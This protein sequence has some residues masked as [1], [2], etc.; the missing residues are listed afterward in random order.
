MNQSEFKKRRQRLMRKMGKGSIAIVPTAPVRQRNS[1]VDHRFRPDSDF[2]YLTGFAEPEAICVLRPGHDEGE[3]LLFCRERDPEKEL[4][5]GLRAGLD[6]AKERYGADEAYPIT[7]LEQYLPKMLENHQRVFYAIGSHEEMDLLLPKWIRQV[8]NM[9]RAGITAPK[10]I[11]ALDHL[12]H[13]LRLIKSK[14]EIKAMKK[15]ADIAADAH[16]RLMQTCKPDMSEHRLEAEFHYRCALDDARE[17]SYPSIVAGGSNACILHYTE[18]DAVMQDGDMV[19]I[20]AGCE[21]D[22]YA[23]DI[24]RTFPVNGKFTTP[25]KALYQLVLDA[26]YAAIDKVKPGNHFNEPH[27]AAV[28]VLTKGL[29]KLGLLKGQPA[30]LIKKEAYKKFFMHRTSHWLGMDVHD[31]GDY[32]V[33]DDWLCFEPGMV[34]TIEPGLYIAAGSKGVAK[35]WR[36]IGIRIE[37]DVLVTKDGNQ[38]LSSNSV[39]KIDEIE[40]LM[41]HDAER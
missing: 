23:S 10:E 16:N 33:N 30:S 5:D 36:G 37:D 11:V 3:Y 13:R 8:R 29:V 28:K 25:Q 21:Y 15:S 7:E 26:Q 17:L 41:N 27:E 20:D 40:A 24:T 38:V 6:G 22:Y 31:V 35:K 12:L 19:L 39:K 32:K 14:T 9:A 4:W 18:N 1:D 34:L 2:I